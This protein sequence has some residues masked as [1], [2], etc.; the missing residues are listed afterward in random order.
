MGEHGSG[1]NLE[2]LLHPDGFLKIYVLDAHAENF[3]RI[4]AYSMTFEI[5]GE[6]NS[7]KQIICEGIEDQSVK[8]SVIL[9]YLPPTERING[10]LPFKAVFLSLKF[11][12]SIIMVLHSS[13]LVIQ[14]N[15]LNSIEEKRDQIVEELSPF[16][17]HLERLTYIIDRAKDL[18]G[19]EEQ[20]KIETF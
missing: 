10:H 18:P 2:L 3:V 14:I 19:L 17:D 1:F 8:P 20:Y 9:L 13:L 4:P 7:T 16:E 6:N 5:Q 11:W 12:N 15:L